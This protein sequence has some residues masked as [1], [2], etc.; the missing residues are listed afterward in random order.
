MVSNES[1]D[2]AG[3]A[4]ADPL[5]ALA[6]AIDALAGQDLAS[7]S[8]ATAAGRALA[9]R[10]LIERAEGEWLRSLA[11]IDARG[12]AGA[13]SGARFR[14]T[15]GWL[16]ATARLSRSSAGEQ[17]R[18][19]RALYGGRLP[20]VANTL[21]AG[22]I[23]HEHA[24]AIARG[25]AGLRAGEA[26]AAEPSAL[27][28]AGKSDPVA[29]RRMAEQL[30]YDLDPESEAEKAR[31]QFDRRRLRTAARQGGMLGLDGLLH[32]E[33]AEI[34]LAAINALAVPTGSDDHRSAA[35]R[36]A[37]ALT[38]LARRAVEAS[39]PPESGSTVQHVNATADLEALL[40]SGAAAGEYTPPG[41]SVTE[42]AGHD[43][44]DVPPSSI[45]ACRDNDTVTDTVTHRR[46]SVGG[47]D[48][49]HSQC[50]EDDS[51]HNEDQG[52]G[53]PDTVDHSYTTDAD[54][55]N[56][57]YGTDGEVHS[58]DGSDTHPDDGSSS[59]RADG[60][61]NGTRGDDHARDHLIDGASTDKGNG[62]NARHGGI[63]HTA[64]VRR[65]R[66]RA[67]LRAAR[68]AL[69]RPST[70]PSHRAVQRRPLQRGDNPLGPNSRS[71]RAL[72]TPV[73]QSATDHPSDATLDWGRYRL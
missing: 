38:D 72:R 57:I 41:A 39:W 71:S 55:S 58:S 23:S 24:A 70:I 26:R 9:L 47:L 13:E 67:L 6:A 69:P 30:R 37:D 10:R 66:V 33:A 40:V 18:T 29:T 5:A 56:P 27:G 36:R 34:V 73:P 11:D 44:S 7:L 32:P 48:S 59:D 35:Q 52:R 4:A 22:Q 20:A 12:A 45:F 8:D 19:A 65:G 17:V 28:V 3:A 62:S 25:L 31:G 51:G 42:T 14:S 54:Y 50:L 49:A 64:S 15:A 53:G 16:R 60:R 21:A 1:S 63:G 2:A 43:D 46:L 61:P 68:E